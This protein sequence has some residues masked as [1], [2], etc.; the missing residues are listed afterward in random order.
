MQNINEDPGNVIWGGAFPSACRTGQA[1][2]TDRLFENQASSLRI[3]SGQPRRLYE[4][5]FALAGLKGNETVLD[6]YCGVGPISFHLAQGASLVWG[7]DE[8]SLSIA[9][10]KQNARMNGFH[11]CRFF[12][13]NVAAKV[14]EAKRC[15]P[16]ID[17]VILNPPRKGLQP[18]AMAAVSS[19]RP[20]RII[21]VFCEPETL[22]RD[23]DKLTSQ[24]YRAPGHMFPETAEVETAA[25]LE[26]N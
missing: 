24:G 19:L 23:L 12:E 26:R 18:D 11:N 21:Y 8:S 7:I 25:L 5:V 22:A 15:L 17:L 1:P 13:G 10:A 9:T 16:C 4:K 20:L 3:L 6:L 14:E 2:G